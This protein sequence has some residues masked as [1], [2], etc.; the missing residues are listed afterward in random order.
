MAWVAIAPTRHSAQGTVTP[1]LVGLVAT[2]TPQ[3]F[4]SGSE[5]TME[6]VPCSHLPYNEAAKAA[7]TGGHFGLFAAPDGRTGWLA[8]SIV[9][10]RAR[11]TRS[12]SLS[13][14]S[15]TFAAACRI[16]TAGRSRV[17]R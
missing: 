5:A 6:N 17:P 10:L 1:T 9:A 11:T 2:A 7:M 14:T 16:R 12:S 4:R 13:A 3:Y 15:A 8:K